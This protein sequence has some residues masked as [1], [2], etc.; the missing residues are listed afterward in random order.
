MLFIF[1]ID[2]IQVRSY[3]SNNG[4]HKNCLPMFGCVRWSRRR[5]VAQ[6]TIQRLLQLKKSPPRKEKYNLVQKIGRPTKKEDDISQEIGWWT[7]DRRSNNPNF[8]SNPVG[9]WTFLEI[10]LRLNEKL[11]AFHLHVPFNDWSKPSPTYK[12]NQGLLCNVLMYFLSV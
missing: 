9:Y 2:N 3:R 4:I 8:A 1:L 12:K 7:A 11:W 10:W 6:R 5:G